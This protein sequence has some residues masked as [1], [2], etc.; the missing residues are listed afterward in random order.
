LTI[1]IKNNWIYYISTNKRKTN[2]T[3]LLIN[4]I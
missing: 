2:S 4:K 3:F 1:L